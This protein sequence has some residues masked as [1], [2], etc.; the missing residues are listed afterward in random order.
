MEVFW[1]WK[2]SCSRCSVKIQLFMVTYYLTTSNLPFSMKESFI[3]TG[4]TL[5]F[6]SRLQTGFRTMHIRS[7]L[8]RWTGHLF[9]RWVR[10][11]SSLHPQRDSLLPETTMPTHQKL[12]L[13]GRLIYFLFVV[14]D[15][16]DNVQSLYQIKKLVCYS[17]MVN[18]FTPAFSKKYS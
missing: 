7:R 15:T 11:R 8:C 6:I 9:E 16:H 10:E 5:R 18:Y 2:W 4:K 13:F 1:F 3:W 17:K 12:C 14:L